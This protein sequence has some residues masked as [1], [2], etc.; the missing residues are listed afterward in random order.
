[1]PGRTRS[2]R[3]HVGLVA[4]DLARQ[5][6][7][8]ADQAHVAAQHVEQLGQLVD[9]VAAQPPARLGDPRV[10]L[11]LEQAGLVAGLGVQLGEPLLGVD[12]HGAELEAAELLA[13]AADPGLPEEDRAAVVRA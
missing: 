4:G 11:H 2:R 7:A 5:R 13:V 10:V 1:M 6:R 9:G 3:E 12:D 8:R